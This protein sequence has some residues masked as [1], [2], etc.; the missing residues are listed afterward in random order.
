MK[1]KEITTYLE[2]IAP[3]YYQENYD[4]SGLIV[5]DENDIV[6]AALVTLDCTEAIIDEALAKG[7]NLVIAHHPIIKPELS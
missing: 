7:C 6:N 3:I 1:I 5:G 4:N 2:T